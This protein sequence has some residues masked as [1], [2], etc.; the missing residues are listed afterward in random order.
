MAATESYHS[1][2]IDNVQLCLPAVFAVL[3]APGQFGLLGHSKNCILKVELMLV[4]NCAL[5]STITENYFSSTV[6]S[7]IKYRTPMHFF[8]K[9]VSCSL[10]CLQDNYTMLVPV[11][12]SE[13]CN[14]ITG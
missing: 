7:E 1:F 6:L 13:T 4:S 14:S 8:M 11:L 12:T 9:I 3:I 10:I 2:S 5:N